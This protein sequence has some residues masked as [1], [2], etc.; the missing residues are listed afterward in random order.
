MTDNTAENPEEFPFPL[1]AHG[2]AW[3]VY[4]RRQQ[5][6]P[7][8]WVR[9]PS[10]DHARLA[11]RH[12]D[13]VRV[14]TDARFSRELTYP[15]APRIA[16]GSDF[17]DDPDIM[18]NMDAPRHTRIRRL[19]NGT[20][21]SRRVEEYRPRIHALAEKRIDGLTGPVIEFVNE[22]AY[23]FAVE[24]ICEV[25]GVV[26]I[27]TERV[28]AWSNNTLPSSGLALDEQIASLQE[29]AA[30][31]MELIERVRDTP[32]DGVLHTMIRARYEG[33]RLTDEEL[34][35]NTI[36]MFTAG[37][38]TTGAVLSRSLLRLLDPRQ[39]YEQLVG[40]PE[41]INTAVEELLRAEVPGDGAPLRVALEDVEMPS[42]V[43]RKGEAVMA[44]L[45]GPN[46]DPDIYDAPEELRLDRETNPHLTLGR[47]PHFCL[48]ANL[49]RVELQEIL[50]AIATKLPDLTLAVA[51]EDLAWTT[52]AFKRPAQLPLRLN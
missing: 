29:F 10:G 21:T 30:Y 47:G 17:T 14:F 41:W 4:R 44:S 13:A 34:V 27:D 11:V 6:C 20:L 23:P 19:L 46:H 24:V 26:G 8:G 28:R 51:A 36:G 33:D 43:I 18:L 40:H 48:G 49:A 22:V 7:L 31:T 38:E 3:D 15:G 2:H 5:E 37:H 9:L 32:G 25:M 39:N 45:V 16:A 52:N 50:S 12:E 42:G 1:D 35:R